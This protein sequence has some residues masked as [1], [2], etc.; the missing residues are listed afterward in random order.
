L[1]SLCRFVPLIGL[2]ADLKQHEL[3][4]IALAV[5]AAARRR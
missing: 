1:K 2:A 5:P 3:L 4:Q